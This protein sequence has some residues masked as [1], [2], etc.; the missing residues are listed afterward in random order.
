MGLSVR[1]WCIFR[2]VN[3]KAVR[4]PFCSLHCFRAC[5]YYSGRQVVPRAST[6]STHAYGGERKTAGYLELENGRVWRSA[7][8]IYD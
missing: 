8:Y 1:G 5:M 3:A 4:A 2:V 6:R 7:W